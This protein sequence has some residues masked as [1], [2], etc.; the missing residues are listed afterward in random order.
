MD[1]MDRIRKVSG[2]FRLLSTLAMVAI[3]LVLTVYWLAFDHLPEDMV[4]GVLPGNTARPLGLVP[5]LLALA[6]CLPPTA[7]LVRGFALLRRLFGLY[8]QGR[9]FSQDVVG[10]YRGLGRTLLAW[11]AAL[12]LQTPLLS[13]ALTSGNPPGSHVIS[14]GIG[15][16]ELTA[17]FLGGLALLI[18]WVMDE[19]RKLDEEQSLTV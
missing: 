13:L 19:G 14:V 4:A 15:T 8:G 17:V 18:S 5:S 7:A 6:A 12:F 10:C 3:P 1:G 2:T 16:G 9:V 11:G